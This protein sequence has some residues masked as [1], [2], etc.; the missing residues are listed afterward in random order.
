MNQTP[1]HAVTGA[2]GYSG[3]YIAGRLLQQGANVIALTNSLSR[4]NP[5]GGRVR[6]FPFHF[7]RPD[8]L[9]QHL[10]DVSVLYNTYWVRFGPYADAVRNTLA[11][12]EAAKRRAS[13]GSFTSA[14]PTPPRFTAGV[15]PGQG[16]T[17]KGAC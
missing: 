15:F 16:Q 14:L 13:S 10:K 1:L 17:R 5:F 12:F 9:V 6:A 2:F 3:K 4:A 7:D 11:L 8:L